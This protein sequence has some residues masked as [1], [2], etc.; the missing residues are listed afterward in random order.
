MSALPVVL[1]IPYRDPAVAFAPLANGNMSV[2]LES[3]LASPQGRYSYIAHDPFSIIR[4]TPHPWRVSV[5]GRSSAEDPFTVLAQT[6][7][8]FPADDP[9][10]PAPFSGG[11][12]G[13]FSYELGGVLERLPAPRGQPCPADMAVGLYDVV[14]AFDHERRESWIISQGFPAVGND[15]LARAQSRAAAL[16]SVL[17]TA[18][19]AAPVRPHSRW[20]PEST[21]AAHESRVGQIL[22][23]IR[24]GE[25]YQ[26]NVTQRFL[27]DLPEGTQPFDLYR[28]LMGRS[29][30]PFAAFLNAGDMALISASPERFLSLGRDRA[31][32]TRPIKGTRPRGRTPAED[33]SFAQDLMTSPKDRAENLMIVDLLRN[34]LSRVCEPGSVRVPALCALETFPAVHHLV[35]SVTGRMREGLTAADLLRATFPGGSITGAPKIHAMEIIH[36]L[37]PAARGPYCGAVAWMGFNGAMDSS[38]VIRTLVKCGNRLIAQAGG[39]IVADSD[40]AQEYDESLTKAAALLSV[41]DEGT[42]A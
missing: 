38:I 39:G 28:L 15:R 25:I 36:A 11:A 1:P 18:P 42:P 14:A 17:G 10:E 23:A 8:R 20:M 31:V 3:A 4:C 19:L 2:L 41:L 37:E 32:E 34:D 24:A 16:A 13:F 6:L 40:P 9:G 26:A 22:E 33:A 27:A 30:A 5:D 21:R 12:I 35:S 7:A 29:P